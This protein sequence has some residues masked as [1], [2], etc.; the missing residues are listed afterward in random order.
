MYPDLSYR[1]SIWQLLTFVV[2]SYNAYKYVYYLT[3]YHFRECVTNLLGVLRLL[4]LQLGM[5]S[6]PFDLLSFCQVLWH[7][8]MHLYFA[9][10]ALHGDANSYKIVEE[11]NCVPM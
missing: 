6:Q 4:K 2:C 8:I 1:H 9:D 3:L 10:R 11:H 7:A 5:H